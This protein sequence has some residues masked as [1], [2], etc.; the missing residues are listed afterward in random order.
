MEMIFKEL[1]NFPELIDSDFYL[2]SVS[3]QIIHYFTDT[4]SVDFS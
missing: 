4:L 2:S 3:L 1:E